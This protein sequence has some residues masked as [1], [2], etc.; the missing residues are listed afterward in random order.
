MEKDS[1]VIL[2]TDLAIVGSLKHH[3]LRQVRTVKTNLAASSIDSYGVAFFPE[4]PRGYSTC[5][6]SPT[7]KAAQTKEVPADDS[8]ADMRV[9]DDAILPNVAVSTDVKKTYRQ[10]RAALIKDIA[11]IMTTLGNADESA[12]YPETFSMTYE[13]SSTRQG[14]AGFVTMPMDNGDWI[15]CRLARW[16]LPRSPSE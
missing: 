3:I 2:L 7:E 10:K 6:L 5:K 14:R 11:D 8:D 13:G 9:D 4:K 1:A 16:G 15:T 12:F